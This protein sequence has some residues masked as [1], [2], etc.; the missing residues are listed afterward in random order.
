[1][2]QSSFQAVTKLEERLE[3][4]RQQRKKLGHELGKFFTLNKRIEQ[5][6][7]FLL[8]FRCWSTVPDMWR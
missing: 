3:Q 4:S 2:D 7:K 5:D 6:R 8:F 1:M